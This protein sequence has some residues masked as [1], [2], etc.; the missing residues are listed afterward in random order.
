MKILWLSWKD[1]SHPQAGGAEHISGEFM[2]RL[3]ADGHTVRHITA[4]YPK[5]PAHETTTVGVEVFRTGN[6]YTTY[7]KAQRTYKSMMK[8]W[9]DIVIDE[10]NTIPYFS[11]S[12][13]KD[14]KTVLLAYQLAREVWFYQMIF[15]LSLI[16]Y[17][18]EPIMLRFMSHHYP[19]V[20]TESQSTKQ[21]LEKYGF[22]RVEVFRAATKLLPTSSL[23][24]KKSL[25]TILSLGS[26]RPMKRTLH[27]VKA[28]ELARDKNL[29]LKLVV[30]GDTTGS[31]AQ[32][33]LRYAHSSRHADAIQIRGRV[34]EEERNEL[35]ES[36][37]LIL[38]TSI[39][40]GWGLTVTEANLRG[41]PAVAYDTDGLRDSIRAGETGLLC[42]PGKPE[43][44]A[45]C[46]SSIL[47]RPADYDA[48][49]RKAWIWSKQF[50]FDNAYSDFTRFLEL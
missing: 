24:P 9:P 46:I 26:I 16:G 12:Y 10:M 32:K 5:A 19:L 41:T 8:N 1:R 38:L 42:E 11:Y 36:A 23:T 4:L 39:K 14:A 31:Y 29:D 44:M 13:S 18:A 48:M 17:M 22:S 50:N 33:V 35:M 28:F 3:V 20:L 27:A 43:R 34:S 21:D 7:L 47:D 40:E 45:D 37:S 2:D 25:T 15:P 49:R 6:R 30:A